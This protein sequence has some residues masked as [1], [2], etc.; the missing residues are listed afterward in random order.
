MMEDESVARVSAMQRAW[1]LLVPT[2][3]LLRTRMAGGTVLPGCCRADEEA[4]YAQMRRRA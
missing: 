2:L 1:K 4:V 3:H